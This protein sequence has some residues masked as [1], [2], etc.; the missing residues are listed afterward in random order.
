MRAR[1]RL[2]LVAALMLASVAPASAR[3]PYDLHIVNPLP[4]RVWV[5]VYHNAS[6]HN[7]FMVPPHFRWHYDSR[8]G[9]MKIM[10]EI[11]ML[12]DDR[13]NPQTICK[14]DMSVPKGSGDVTIHLNTANNSCW[15]TR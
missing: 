10:A 9:N 7:A 8:Q 1:Y 5:T 14:T 3:L 11:K 4:N 2:P 15:W 12:G 13:A 6:I